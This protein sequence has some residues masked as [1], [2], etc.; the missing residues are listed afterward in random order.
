MR[1]PATSLFAGVLSFLFACGDPL[2]ATGQHRLALEDDPLLEQLRALPGVTA[3][4]RP[5]PSGTRGF[6]L[7]F[8]Q[9]IDHTRPERGAF[10]QR[11]LLRHRDVSRPMV[12]ASTGY[13]LFTAQPVDT[14]PSALLQANSLYLEHRF[15]D[16]STPE[17]LDW[18]ALTIRQAAADHH[19]VVELLKRIYPAHW[20][21]TG[22]SKGGMTSLYHRRFYPQDIDGTVAYVAP[23]S[24]GTDDPRYPAFLE[25]VGSAECRARIIDFQRALL[26]RADELLPL[27]QAQADADGLTYQRVGGLDVAFEHGAQEFRFA[28]W[29]YGDEE[30]CATLPPA[31][32]PASALMSTLDMV[33]G[34]AN[35]ASDQILSYFDAYYYQAAAQLGSYGPLEFHLRPLL[36]HP[37]TYR[38][39]RYSPAPVRRFDFRAMPETQ[40]WL[41]LHGERVMLIYGEND[42][43]SAGAFQLGL[44]RDSYRYV[45]PGGNHNTSYISV[46]PEPQRS[47]ALATLARWAGVSA[48]APPAM[49]S[50]PA[51]ASSLPQEWGLDRRRPRLNE[52][53]PR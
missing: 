27:F 50:G 37:G 18:D 20:L 14:E 3:E 2:D 24:Y 5:A 7:T 44:A 25:H 22:G 10:T 4:E 47:E 29:Q 11:A 45:M 42:P 36:R 16:A 21:S 52:L 17:T 38:V 35:L 31:G 51:A 9:P 30:F 12:L 8:Q 1:L 23:N 34:P 15:F 26:S 41:A 53:T 40:A 6:L 19:H 43:W 48:E 33:S 39:E 13:G 46:L 49:R 32:A 28:L